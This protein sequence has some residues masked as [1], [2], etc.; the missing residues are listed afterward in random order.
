MSAGMHYYNENVGVKD[1]RISSIIEKAG[2]N[3]KMNSMSIRRS[4]V[5]TD[6]MLADSIV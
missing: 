1:N 4:P 5:N 3:N 2:S 6:S